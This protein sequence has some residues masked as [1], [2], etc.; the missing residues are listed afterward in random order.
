M[1]FPSEKKV[2]DKLKI[3]VLTDFYQFSIVKLDV[4]LNKNPNWQMPTPKNF[5]ALVLVH[6]IVGL[7]EFF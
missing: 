1:I 5:E 4:L 3:C 2:L 6:V 7:P